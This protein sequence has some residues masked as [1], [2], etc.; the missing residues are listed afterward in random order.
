MLPTKLDRLALFIVVIAGA[1]GQAQP[2]ASASPASDDYRVV[3]TFRVGGVGG[4]DYLTV[5]A[6]HH[7]LYVPRSTHTMVVDAASGKTVAD[8]A[9][10][11]RNHG[12]A[13]VPWP[14]AGSFPMARTLP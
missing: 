1:V 10:Q 3:R 9:G 5:D 14:A 2:A 13:I 12:V 6:R 8:I 11:R 7:L 4:W